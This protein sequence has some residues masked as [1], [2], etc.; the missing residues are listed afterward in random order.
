[1][2]H[3]SALRRTSIVLSLQ[4]RPI[5]HSHMFALLQV[6]SPEIM[7]DLP[8]EQFSHAMG[9]AW[10]ASLGPVWRPGRAMSHYAVQVIV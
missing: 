4:L 8:Y 10:L 1:M 2:V 6:D 3:L 5:L 7:L 9:V